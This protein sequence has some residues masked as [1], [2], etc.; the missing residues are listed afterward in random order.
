MKSMMGLHQSSSF[1]TPAHRGEVLSFDH[2][3]VVLGCLGP[4]A[5]LKACVGPR[6]TC[7]LEL[8]LIDS[9]VWKAHRQR[10]CCFVGRAG[11]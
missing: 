5:L 11:I 4:E 3:E 2:L 10:C 9:L 6:R 8:E 7:L 1:Q